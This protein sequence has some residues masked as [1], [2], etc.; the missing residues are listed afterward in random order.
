MD[1]TVWGVGTVRVFYTHVFTCTCLRRTWHEA[2]CCSVWVDSRVDM[3][4]LGLI[5]LS[6]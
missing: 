2:L 4:G 3:F 1:D 5:Y 6:R